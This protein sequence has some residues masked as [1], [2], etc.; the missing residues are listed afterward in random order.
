MAGVWYETLGDLSSV[1]AACETNYT[2]ISVVRGRDDG[3][4]I[5]L[6]NKSRAVVFFDSYK[7]TRSGHPKNFNEQLCRRKGKL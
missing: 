1:P 6:N 7:D 5:Y 2:I 4:I 3:N